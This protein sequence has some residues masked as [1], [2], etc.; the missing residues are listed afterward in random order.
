MPSAALKNWRND[1]MQR[2]AEIDAQCIAAAFAGP[3]SPFLAEE[4][5]RGYVLL[6]SGHFQG[7]CRDL[8]TECAQAFEATLGLRVRA[9]IRTQFSTELKLNSQNPTVEAIRKDFE[10]FA[11]SLDFDSDLANGARVTH[12]G[13]LNKWRN[14]I[15]HQNPS[16][17][18]GAL[19]LTLTAVQQWRV[20][21]DGLATWLDD[22]MYRAMFRIINV[23]PW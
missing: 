11:V 19:P 6:I 16:P 15:A 9:T 20:S 22:M 4:N 8:Y 1:R 13:Q 14:A 18:A 2:L 17:P 5:L 3:S 7:Y 10:R 21:C 23:A 12:L